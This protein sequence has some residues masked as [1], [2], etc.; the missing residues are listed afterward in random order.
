MKAEESME[1]Y[2]GQG[3]CGNMQHK[4]WNLLENPNSSFAAKV[5][6]QIL[7]FQLSFRGVKVK[8]IL[9]DNLLDRGGG[10]VSFCRGFNSIAHHLNSS[11]VSSGKQIKI[12][13]K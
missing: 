6:P 1:D 9:I 3:L 10:V 7:Q 2:F 8:A 12:E 5:S 13:N 11:H 4:L